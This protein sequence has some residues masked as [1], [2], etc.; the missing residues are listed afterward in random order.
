V[1]V[2]N[3]SLDRNEI[4]PEG[5]VAL[6]K[7]LAVNQT[8]QTL[9]IQLLCLELLWTHRCYHHEGSCEILCIFLQQQIG[10]V[11]DIP[12]FY[13]PDSK[14]DWWISEVFNRNCV[15]PCKGMKVLSA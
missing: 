13:I 1:C 8:L 14:V 7:A 11:V 12:I 6:G 9:R 10:Q 15:K 2:P 5:G 4:G 3:Y